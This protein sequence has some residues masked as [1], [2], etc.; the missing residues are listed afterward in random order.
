MTPTQELYDALEVA[1]GLF[2]NELFEN[3]LPTLIFTTQRQNSVMG[4]FAPDRW[5]SV[6]GKNCHEL[7]INP[8]YVGKMH[9]LSFLQTMVHEMV[10]CLQRCVGQPG[11][12]G[13]H[14]KE[15][16]AMMEAVGLTPSATGKPGGK[17][18]GERMS[19]YPTPRGP[20]M[21]AC[22]T[23]VLETNFRLQWYEYRPRGTIVS[24]DEIFHGTF[25]GIK[26][27]AVRILKGCFEA[28]TNSAKDHDES[29]IEEPMPT[30]KREKTKY[31]CPKCK[32][33]VWGK[34]LLKIA[35]VKCSLELTT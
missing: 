28:D 25:D 2:N 33:N 7:A 20:F 13:Y 26:P 34:P 19:D 9:L 6:E 17:K 18:T 32:L 22:E 14:N 27:E 11:R 4:Y 3:R 35:C 16:G 5:A 30:A 29:V 31:S 21:K 1:Y 24:Q 10:H 8:S 15:W 12:R 23:L